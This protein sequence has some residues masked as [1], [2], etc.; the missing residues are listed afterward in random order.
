MKCSQI[1][2]SPTGVHDWFGKVAAWHCMCPCNLQ[3][4][5]VKWQC[6]LFLSLQEVATAKAEHACIHR[7]RSDHTWAQDYIN[8]CTGMAPHATSQFSCSTAS[9]SHQPCVETCLFTYSRVSH[10]IFTI[11]QAF[12]LTIGCTSKCRT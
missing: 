9:H 4:A 11:G 1:F 8:Y 2:G 6:F 10:I 7:G 3:G 5:H 12:L